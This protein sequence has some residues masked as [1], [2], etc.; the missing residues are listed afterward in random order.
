MKEV[1]MNHLWKIDLGLYPTPEEKKLPDIVRGIRA[2]A[3]WEMGEHAAAFAWA[4]RILPTKVEV[5]NSSVFCTCLGVERGDKDYRYD[6]T[7]VGNLMAR[8][9]AEHILEK[10]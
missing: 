1:V 4:A 6:L 8:M 2:I 10:A 3:L 9:L 7:Q 5:G